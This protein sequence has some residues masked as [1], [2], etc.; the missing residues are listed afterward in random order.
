M[1]TVFVL[2]KD[3]ETSETHLAKRRDDKTDMVLAPVPVRIGLGRCEC[4]VLD[5]VRVDDGVKEVVVDGVVDVR[6]LVIVAP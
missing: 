4:A 1:I 6:V 3:K 2:A 5:K